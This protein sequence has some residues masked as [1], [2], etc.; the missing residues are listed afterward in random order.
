MGTAA[1]LAALIAWA[2]ATERA[3]S[4][5]EWTY[6]LEAAFILATG[7]SMLAFGLAVIRTGAIPRWLGWVAIGWSIGWL[8]RF[9]MPHQGYPR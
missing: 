3:L 9:A 6:R 7:I 8:I 2:A 4:A 5:H 1:Y